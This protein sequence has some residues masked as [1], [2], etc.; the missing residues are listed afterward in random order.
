MNSVVQND[1]NKKKYQ[2]IIRT[3]QEIPANKILKNYDYCKEGTVP[4]SK[5]ENHIFQ[6]NSGKQEKLRVTSLQ[7][8]Y[9]TARKNSLPIKQGVYPL[10][11][12][13]GACIDTGVTRS[14]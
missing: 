10:R 14:V 6:K 1:E 7:D 13:E 3:I 8:L 9:S 11:Q 5:H 4:L 12:F 2:G